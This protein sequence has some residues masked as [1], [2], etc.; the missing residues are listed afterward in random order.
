[1]KRLLAIVVSCS[2]VVLM[3]SP[4][5]AED[6]DSITKKQQKRMQQLMQAQRSKAPGIDVKQERLKPPVEGGIHG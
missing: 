1:M 5:F 4:L 2:I 3:G 6:E